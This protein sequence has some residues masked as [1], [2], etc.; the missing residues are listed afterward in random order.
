MERILPYLSSERIRRAERFHREA[1]RLMSLGGAYLVEKYACSYREVYLNN[2]GK[3]L[4]PGV[5]FNLS[6]SRDLVALAVSGCAPVGIDLEYEDR[7]WSEELSRHCFSTEEL[8]L[9]EHM[10]HPLRFFVAKESLAKAEGSG[11]TNSLKE[12]PAIPLEGRVYYRG[13]DYYR[14]QWE[15]PGCFVSITQKDHDF[16]IEEVIHDEW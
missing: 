7:N 10:D 5:F 8:I 3:P 14:R 2:Y 1:D 12:I 15:R 9:A 11:L 13:T 4:A 16:L 6:H